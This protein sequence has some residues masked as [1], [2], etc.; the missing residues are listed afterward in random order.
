MYKKQRSEMWKI[1]RRLYILFI[2]FERSY[3]SMYG[4]R[5]VYL[6]LVLC[7]RVLSFSWVYIPLVCSTL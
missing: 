6:F 5:R 3:F 7:E 4:E 2:S 1:W